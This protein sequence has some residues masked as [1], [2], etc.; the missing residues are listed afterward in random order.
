MRGALP[1]KAA[2]TRRWPDRQFFEGDHREAESE[3]LAKKYRVVIEG[4]DSKDE[5]V[6]QRWAR[7]SLHYE[8]VHRG[9]IASDVSKLSMSNRREC[10]DAP[11]VG[12]S[13]TIWKINAR[14]SG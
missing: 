4:G 1:K 8:E 10:S 6:G 5:S 11:H 3:G 2:L 12:F 13:A 9:T 7:S 14:I